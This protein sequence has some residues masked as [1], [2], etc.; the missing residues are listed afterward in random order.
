MKIFRVVFLSVAPFVIR[1]Q[2][3]EPPQR[4]VVFPHPPSSN[5][6]TSILIPQHSV[7][8]NSFLHPVSFLCFPSEL[9]NFIPPL[10]DVAVE[11]FAFAS[12]KQKSL[13]L[14]D[15]LLVCFVANCRSY[16]TYVALNRVS[17]SSS[18]IHQTYSRQGQHGNTCRCSEYHTDSSTTLLSRSN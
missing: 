15:R 17:T 5:P 6:F 2:C 14:P 12:V 1:K 4:L 10:R 13:Q 16:K 8:L 11:T 9:L 3:S 18:S 7:F